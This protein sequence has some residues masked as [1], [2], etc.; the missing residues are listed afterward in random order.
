V[1]PTFKVAVIH[2]LRPFEQGEGG[3]TVICLLE[4]LKVFANTVTVSV[5]ELL[6]SGLVL[7]IKASTK[8]VCHRN[9][10]STENFL[11]LKTEDVKK[12]QKEA[13]GEAVIKASVEEKEEVRDDAR[14]ETS[15]S[16]RQSR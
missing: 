15:E 1:V 4:S 12:H 13:P 8:T 5:D 2:H 6:L 14:P 11:E 7:E 10:P 16:P 9:L 3:D